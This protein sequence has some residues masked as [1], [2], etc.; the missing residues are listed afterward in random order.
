MADPACH[1][2]DNDMI[3]VVQAEDG[4]VITDPE[5]I[6]NRFSEYYEALY[7]SK[8]APNRETLLD[9]LLH[10]E[11]PWLTAA[12]RE[13]FMVPMSLEEIGRA[14]WG[15]AKGKS[16]AEL[17]RLQDDCALAELHQPPSDPCFNP[18]LVLNY[19]PQ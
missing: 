10:I 2:R 12:D 6:A 17:A 15:M 14:L 4:S 9:Y 13:S 18:V 1:N 16:G 3:V 5:H 11:L 19:D 7:T 8:I